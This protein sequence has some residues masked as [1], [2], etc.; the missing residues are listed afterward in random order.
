VELNNTSNVNITDIQSG[1]VYALFYSSGKL[2]VANP[3]GSFY[4]RI[5]FEDA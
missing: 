1:S 3:T 4:S 5:R 2:G